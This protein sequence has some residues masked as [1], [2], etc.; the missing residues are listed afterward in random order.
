[1]IDD[2]TPYIQSQF[3]RE[4]Y[5]LLASLST[6][7]LQSLIRNAKKRDKRIRRELGYSESKVFHCPLEDVPLYINDCNPLTVQIAKWRLQL[8]K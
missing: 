3:N 6:Y 8:N 4:D 7:Y 5:T 2:V 1:M